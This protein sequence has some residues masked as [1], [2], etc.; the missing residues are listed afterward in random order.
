[1]VDG[2]RKHGRAT[3]VL[4]IA[5]LMLAAC[6]DVP[7]SGPVVAG[8]PVRDPGPPPYVAF[9]A[10]SPSPGDEP[11]GIV[12]GFLDAM[13]AYQPGY[14][15]ATMFLTP[16]AQASW[17]PMA[18]I[19]V[20]RGARPSIEE[21]DDNVIRMTIAVAGTVDENGSFEVAE[22]GT[23]REIDLQM[24]QIDGEWRIANPPEGTL[25]SEDIFAREFESHNLCFFS[26]D[27]EVFVLDPVYVPINAQTATLLTQ[28][29]LD[30]PSEWLDPAVHT[31]FPE[32]VA[33]GVSS[34]P[35]EAG[36][37][38]VDL[39]V[40][41][42][43]A[44]P[45]QREWMAAQL[46]CTLSGLPEVTNI[47]LDSDGV[48][49]LSQD[50]PTIPATIDERYDLQRPGTVSVLTA[51]QDGAVVQR[52]DNEYEPVPGALGDPADVLDIAVRPVGDDVAVIG[53][54]GFT[55]RVGTLSDGAQPDVIYEG[56][57]LTSPSWDRN[58]VIWAV[59]RIDDEGDLVAL[60]P[61]GTELEVRSEWL[62]DA[63]VSNVSVSPDG[64]RMV[65]VADGA[66][67]LALVVHDT[68][69]RERVSV[70]RPRRIGPA[71]TAVD[72]DFSGA[73]HIALL[74]E[75][76]SDEPDAEEAEHREVDVY[77]LDIFGSVVANRGS[78]LDATSVAA[79]ATGGTVVA[80]EEGLLLEHETRNRWAD[81]GEGTAPVF[82]RE[83]VS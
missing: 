7:T 53:D 30:G 54:G 51:V 20:H 73:E 11:A 36:V 21:L 19:T 70:E 57:G 32:R 6:A 23:T 74:S 2:N 38:T 45:A 28:M 16:D 17:E 47:A 34:V 65:V 81:A 4:A 22:P 35:V 5:V 68:E 13:R 75:E 14:E 48:P 29:L 78:V 60:R 33:L 76:K 59:D 61:D 66:A 39:S 24:A 50:Q 3:A 9:A 49:L 25:I 46:A 72:V 27:L 77:L 83:T 8:N 52:Q 69:N 1:M 82:V 62:K 79:D 44:E 18:G 37:A 67:Y 26:P 31:A 56:A 80:T 41:A 71:G 15:T 40:A 42:Q 12:D 43:D 63:D 55:V 58:D 64:V 10:A